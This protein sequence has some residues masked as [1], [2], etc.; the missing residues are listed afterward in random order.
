MIPA[1]LQFTPHSRA[2]DVA[3]YLMLG[4]IQD[5]NRRIGGWLPL[6]FPLQSSELVLISVCLN[7]SVLSVIRNHQQCIL[8]LDVEGRFQIVYGV[9]EARS[10]AGRYTM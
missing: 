9:L 10:Q 5:Y 6:G 8:L 3:K 7:I 2:A 1:N 4:T